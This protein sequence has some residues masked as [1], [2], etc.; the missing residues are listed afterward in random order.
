MTVNVYGGVSR[1][2]SSDKEDEALGFLKRKLFAT[3]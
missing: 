3:L 2:N 1:Y